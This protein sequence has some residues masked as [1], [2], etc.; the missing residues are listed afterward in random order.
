MCLLLCNCHWDWLFAIL[1]P[2]GKLHLVTTLR[3]SCHTLTFNNWEKFVSVSTLWKVFRNS[4][5]SFG[6]TRGHFLRLEAHGVHICWDSWKCIQNFKAFLGWASSSKCVLKLKS[7]KFQCSLSLQHEWRCD[8][9]V[10]H[11][12]TCHPPPSQTWTRSPLPAPIWNLLTVT[13]HYTAP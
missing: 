11:S 4:L 1:D 10:S 3:T 7:L 8:V 9:T 13:I 5:Q 12:T 6:K 2:F